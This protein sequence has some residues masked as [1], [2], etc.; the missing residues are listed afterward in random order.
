MP[1]TSAAS[2]SPRRIASTPSW[3]AVPPEAQAVEVAIGEPLVPNRSAR[4]FAD[5]AE[6]EALDT[7]RS[8]RAVA[9]G[10]QQVVVG[11]GLVA[12]GA[13]ASGA[14]LRPLHL[15]RRQRQEQRA[16]K[17]AR[18]PMPA[19]ARAS[20]ITSSARRFRQRRGRWFRHR[21]EIDGAGDRGAQPVDRKA[22]EIRRMPETAPVSARQFSAWPWPSEVM[23]PMPGAPRRPA[24]P[25]DRCPRPAMRRILPLRS[26]RP[27]PAPRRASGPSTSPAPA[28]AAPP[29][30]PSAASSG[31][32][33][34]PMPHRHRRECQAGR[35]RRLQAEWP[36]AVAV[37]RTGSPSSCQ[38]RRFLP[39][40]Q[41]RAAR[42]PDI[43]AAAARSSVGRHRAE[44][45]ARRWRSPGRARAGSG[46]C[47]TRRS[48][49][50][51][52]APR[53]AACARLSITRKQPTEPSTSPPPCRLPRPRP[54]SEGRPACSA[55][56]HLIDA[57]ARPAAARCTTRRPA[58]CR[59]GPP[60]SA[61]RR[62]APR[63]RRRLP[64]P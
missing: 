37:A 33:S 52:A 46:R 28:A 17:I 12:R 1:T 16:R 61:R 14:A 56:A 62:C 11:D 7:T 30:A 50:Y 9:G 49:R 45:R 19:S 6:Q 58:P 44:L 41:R 2:V 8:K 43:T 31:G 40:R 25:D 53:A 42:R 29:S 39:R 51:G 18:S 10:T 48:A 63:R 20:S 5:R 26:R 4:C 36:S 64:R 47:A 60:R 15:H 27:A 54:P 13:A 21:H 38:E 35:E 24:G 32:N 23:M 3:I 57:A 34:R 22:G 55:L 59:P